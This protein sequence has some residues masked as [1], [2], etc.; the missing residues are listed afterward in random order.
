[1]LYVKP[2]VQIFLEEFAHPRRQCWFT[3]GIF[4]VSEGHLDA[5]FLVESD[6]GMINVGNF[7]EG[8]F[9]LHYKFG[10]TESGV[11]RH[12]DRPQMPSWEAQDPQL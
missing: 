11:C 4:D 8:D 5:L 2:P 6:R 3:P 7:R 1:M 10:D 12:L 9:V